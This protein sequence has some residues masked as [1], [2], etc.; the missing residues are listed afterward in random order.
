L[1]NYSSENGMRVGAILDD[2]VVDLTQLAAG[3][4]GRPAKLR[5][6][7]D[8]LT[9]PPEDRAGL[10]DAASQRERVPLS[11]VRLSPP[12]RLS[13]LMLCCGMNFA[14]HR[15]EMLEQDGRGPTWF[16][17]NHN[18]IVADGED[19]IIPDDHPDMVDFEGEIAVVLGRDCH[20][21]SAEAAMAYVGGYTLIN[22]VTARNWAPGAPLEHADP[23][24]GVILQQTA[25]Q[26]PT[27]CPTGPAVLTADEVADP[28]G[29]TFTTELNGVVMQEGRLT[30]LVMSVP[31]LITAVSRTYRLRPGD[32]VST[33]SPSGTGF[34]RIPP[35][36]LAAGDVV[37]VRSP[38]IGALRNP[39]RSARSTDRWA[40]GNGAVRAAASGWRPLQTTNQPGG[41]GREH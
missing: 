13:P 11:S 10:A 35:R 1:I 18:A 3:T 9:L 24:R 36:F 7:E 28:A 23:V 41:Q 16:I 37:T 31:E 15:S 22:D 38:G 34:G 12:V 27:F 26:Y 32:V 30:D 40:A 2:S 25:K 33:G 5:S 20:M 29:I 17:K 19:I 14:A 39:V 6:V 4:R 21:V 8:V